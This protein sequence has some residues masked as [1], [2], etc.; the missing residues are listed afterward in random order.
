MLMLQLNAIIHCWRH[1]PISSECTALTVK[2]Y[3]SC[4]CL[5]P[6][7]SEICRGIP[8]IERH[9]LQPSLRTNTSLSESFTVELFCTFSRFCRVETPLQLTK[10]NV[11]YGLTRY[12]RF[13]SSCDQTPAKHELCGT[14]ASPSAT[15]EE[16]MCWIFCVPRSV[17]QH[18]TLLVFKFMIHNLKLVNNY[19]NVHL[20]SC[21]NSRIFCLQ[22]T[23]SRF[24]A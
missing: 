3:F 16:A 24:I 5:R 17:Y 11:I 14:A 9:C 19:T 23:Y 13:T 1:E 15:K 7:V 2:L 12:I 20:L 6:I 18:Q 4:N 8:N 21:S 10:T 22:R